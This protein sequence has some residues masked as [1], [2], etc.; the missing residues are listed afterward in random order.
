MIVRYDTREKVVGAFML[1]IMILLALTVLAIGRSKDWFR[2]KVTYFTTFKE[3]YNLETNAAVK[4]FNADIGKVREVT[5]VGNVVHVR[6]SIFAEYA[7]RIRKDSI[8][9]VQSV[10]YIGNK[11][12]S[13]TPGTPESPQLLADEEI[14]SEEQ[15]SV[16]DLLAKFE[17]EETAKMVIR[18]V[19]DVSEVA[20]L[21]RDPEGPLFAALTSINNS[22]SAVE[23]RV[24]AILDSLAVAVDKVP[25]TVDLV[26]R[27]LEKVHEIGVE[28]Q[29][30]I[31]LLQQVL[32]NVE[33]GSR[34]VPA[35]TETTVKGIEEI[36]VGVEQIDEV[37][38][39]LKKSILIRGNLPPGPEVQVNDAGSRP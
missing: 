9:T 39:S 20:T 28:I 2:E 22:L 25:H 30:N 27:D 8:A 18:A 14:S 15:Q 17:V 31:A 13:I 37:V 38:K 26:D 16:A 32:T 10:N 23:V 5:L 1:S 11:Y 12:I 3:S 4:L 36:R 24:G 6:M 34:D 7:P 33:V 21:L 29:A 35:I 19:Q